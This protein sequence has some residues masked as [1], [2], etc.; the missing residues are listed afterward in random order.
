MGLMRFTTGVAMAALVAGS[1]MAQTTAPTAPAGQAAGTLDP[2]AEQA[3]A[4]APVTQP[5]FTLA[6]GIV[7]TVNDQV[8]TGFDLRQRIL[9]VIVMSQV[10][11]TEENIPAIQQQALQALIEE[12]LQAQEIA[13]YE[14][15]KISDEDVSQEIAG[16][17]QEAGT[18]PENYL[19]F[20]A[21]GGIRPS[22]MREQ[23]RT[24]I[25]WRELVRGRFGSRSRVS[26]AQVDQAVRQLT[27]AASKPQY[28]IG[29]IYLEANR[30]GGQQAALNGAEQLVAQMVQGA[31]FQNVARQFSA[32][33]S[34]A[35]GGDAGWVVQ[36]SVQPALQT[37]LESLQ[38]GQL[39]RP[40]PVEGGVYI[41]YMRDKRSGAA[42]S[43]VTL[44]QAMIEL[45]E[46]ASRWM[47]SGV[48]TGLEIVF[49]SAE[50]ATCWNWGARLATSLSP[51]SEPSRP[52][53]EV[54]R[55]RM[56]S[57]VRLGRRAS[58]RWVAA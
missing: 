52:A 19:A 6:D 43:L 53:S 18:T 30:V 13:T 58:R 47:P 4:A 54:A 51:R 11:P 42:T 31:P 9:A 48:R 17:A 29:E 45:P 34:A 5:E 22:S 21:Q 15:L 56:L 35:R 57:Q 36:G 28:L 39:S 10:Q 46:T 23:L 14:T 24:E 38:V 44:K 8:I 50:R 26:R 20:L 49:S 3:P 41:I 2:A 7:A 40:I 16:M 33:P 27:E 25:G 1:A 37:A 32:A 12:R 55:C